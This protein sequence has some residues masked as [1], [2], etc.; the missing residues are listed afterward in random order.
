V[1]QQI[2]GPS[3]S[4][5][6]GRLP[7][8]QATFSTSPPIVKPPAIPGAFLGAKGNPYA[9]LGLDENGRA[10]IDWGVYGVPETF[11][12]QG[13]GSIACKVVGL[14]L[15]GMCSSSRRKFDLVI[16]LKTRQ[17]PEIAQ[18]SAL[19]GVQ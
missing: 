1:R 4:K 11:I 3:P 16:N 6:L 10:G 7:G 12:V 2:Y 18:A 13:D 5:R 9:K 17:R 15:P 14:G 8:R 19:I